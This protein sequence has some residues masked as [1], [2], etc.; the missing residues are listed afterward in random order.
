MNE[1]DENTEAEGK[2]DARGSTR[3]LRATDNILTRFCKKYLADD[4]NR[5]YDCDNFSKL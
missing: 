2:K 5:N 1:V 4:E 3:G